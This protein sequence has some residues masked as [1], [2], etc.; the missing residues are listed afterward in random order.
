M[1]IMSTSPSTRTNPIAGK[2]ARTYIT[3]FK[4][5]AGKPVTD[6]QI[7][8]ALSEAAK[9]VIAIHN[10]SFPTIDFGQFLE[11]KITEYERFIEFY[12]R[13]GHRPEVEHSQRR[14]GGR[15]LP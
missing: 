14:P 7:V 10:E 5:L 6:D 4:A 15:H 12:D 1:S 9:S 13:F 8:E 2:W 11:I 3:Y